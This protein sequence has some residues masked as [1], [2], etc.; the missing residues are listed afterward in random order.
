MKISSRSRP[1]VILRKRTREYRSLR[2]LMMGVPVN[3]QRDSARRLEAARAD[4]VFGLRMMWPS[5]RITRRHCTEKRPCLRGMGGGLLLV[6]PRGIY[7]VDS[8]P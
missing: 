7:S 1:P 3:T 2:L 8:V 6:L 4:F 5:S